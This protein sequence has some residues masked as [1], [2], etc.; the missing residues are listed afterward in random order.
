MITA[1]IVDLLLSWQHPG[2]SVFRR[3]PTEPDDWAA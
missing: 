3:E 1:R 2:F